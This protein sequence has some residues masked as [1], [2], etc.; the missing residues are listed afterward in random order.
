MGEGRA[1]SAVG[2]FIPFPRQV[3]ESVLLSLSWHG[4]PVLSPVC[5][6][7]RFRGTNYT[8]FGPTYAACVLS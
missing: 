3:G 7:S 2:S 1:G 4:M 6:R 8:L 5:I